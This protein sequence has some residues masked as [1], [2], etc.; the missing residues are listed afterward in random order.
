MAAAAF[1]ALEEEP[2]GGEAAEA[3]EE[4]RWGGMGRLEQ[5]GAA[6]GQGHGQHEGQGGS[7]KGK[8]AGISLSPP[9][10]FSPHRLFGETAKG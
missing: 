1:V 6:V 5:L 9:L 8:G 3:H 7:G 4:V 10:L 2:E